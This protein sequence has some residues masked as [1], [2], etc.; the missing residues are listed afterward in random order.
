[1]FSDK[2][3]F[4]LLYT[5]SQLSQRNGKVSRMNRNFAILL[6]PVTQRSNIFRPSDGPEGLAMHMIVRRFPGAAHLAEEGKAKTQATLVPMLQSHQG[7]KGYAAFESEQGHICTCTIYE[8]AEAAE[9][10]AAQVRA[11]VQDNM[12]KLPTPEVYS[13]TVG[14]HRPLKARGA[15]Q[16]LYCFIRL[17]ENVSAATTQPLGQPVLDSVRDMPGFEGAYLMRTT[18]DPTK[19]IAVWFCASRES[20]MDLHET[21]M[22]RHREQNPGTQLRLVATGEVPIL[23]F[24]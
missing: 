3:V 10:S 18:A 11:W 14:A 4:S 7:F 8:D 2:H 17:A 13:G 9:Q 22:Q 19:A 6:T 16:S 21:T 20:A 1:M 23:A 5:I 12:S 15:G 24:P